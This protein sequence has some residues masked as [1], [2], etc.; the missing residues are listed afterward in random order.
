MIVSL[1]EGR[2]FINRSLSSLLTYF[3]S[4]YPFIETNEGDELV[5][6]TKLKE[7]ERR[8]HGNLLSSIKP[9]S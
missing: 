7:M 5:G 9:S 3:L 4:L 2:R 8:M 6:R 1:L